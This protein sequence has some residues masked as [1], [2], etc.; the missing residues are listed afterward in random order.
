MNEWIDTLTEQQQRA[1]ASQS[2]IPG[3][4]A[5]PLDKLVDALKASNNT[6]RIYEKAQ[7]AGL[8]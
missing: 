3:W 1:L 8:E 2:G 4:S 5:C 6:Q 7:L